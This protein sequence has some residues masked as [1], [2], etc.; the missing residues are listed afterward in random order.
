MQLVEVGVGRRQQRRVIVL[1]IVLLGLCLGQAF[2]L[3]IGFAVVLER[4]RQRVAVIDGPYRFAIHLGYVLVAGATPHIGLVVGVGQ[5]RAHGAGI[6]GIQTNEGATVIVAAKRLRHVQTSLVRRVDGG[7]G[8][9]T[10]GGAADRRIHIGITLQHGNVA[11]VFGVAVLGRIDFVVTAVVDRCTVDGGTDFVTGEAA[12]AVVAIGK[13]TEVV[14]GRIDARNAVDQLHERGAW[15]RMN[16][17]IT[18]NRRN[19]LRRCLHRHQATTKRQRF[20][21]HLHRRQLLHTLGVVGRCGVRRAGDTDALRGLG[22]GISVCS[23]I[24]GCLRHHSASSHET[25]KRNRCG[26]VVSLH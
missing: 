23:L 10:A 18:G 17:G 22:G 12:N 13:T 9:G 4:R 21:L 1:V 3:D 8:D 26:K 16:D 5:P 19:S 15:R 11:D 24:S 6:A 7:P 2:V 14:S 20:P 25:G